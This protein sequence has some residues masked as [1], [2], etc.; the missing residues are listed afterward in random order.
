MNLKALSGRA[1]IATFG[2]A[3][4][5]WLT[6]FTPGPA[7][8]QDKALDA[9]ALSA[10][11][12]TLAGAKV[13][14]IAPSPVAGLYEVIVRG[15][16]IYI[17]ATGKHLVDGQVLEVATRSSVTERRKQEY[18]TANT[19]PMDVTQLD[20]ADAIKTVNGKEVPGRMLVSFEDPR[21]TFCKQL[22]QTL[23]AVPDLV[24]YTFPLSFLG[25]ESRAMNEVIWCTAD[26]GKAWG[27]A[28]K[29]L[30]PTGSGQT[31]DLQALE[32]NMELAKQFRITGTPTLFTASGLRIAGAVGAPA[33]EA[34]LRTSSAR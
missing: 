2:L 25:P 14:S 3:A 15:N 34:A 32:R 1:W 26:R 29:S 17:D 7:R 12:E 22:H 9:Q 5:A 23:A 11:V 16:I 21:C 10:I 27:D 24:L 30:P 31:C 6:L 18:E 33:I 13:E 20:L 8:A 19:P 28:M 4:A